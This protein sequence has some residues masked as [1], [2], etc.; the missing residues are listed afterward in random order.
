VIDFVPYDMACLLLS[1]MD[2]DP[3]WPPWIG[4][5]GPAGPGR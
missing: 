1:R 3:A 5:K 2:K 4:P